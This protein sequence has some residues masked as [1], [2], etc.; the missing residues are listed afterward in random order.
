MS[1]RAIGGLIAVF[2]CSSAEGEKREVVSALDE[3]TRLPGRA[4]YSN[5]L[6]QLT[7]EDTKRITELLMQRATGQPYELLEQIEHE[8]L[9]DYRRSWH[10]AD[11]EH[12]KSGCQQIAENIMEAI[13]TFR[14]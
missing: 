7:L 14:D 9:I 3:A 12:D 8:M 13:I 2:K 4:S 6:L 10:F 11:D 1:D 5:E